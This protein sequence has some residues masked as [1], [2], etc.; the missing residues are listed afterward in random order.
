MSTMNR[1][2][3]KFSAYLRCRV[4]RGENNQ[5]YLERYH[6][7]HLPFGIHIYLHRFVASDPGRALHNHPWR[8]ALSLVLCGG[9]EETRLAD[10]RRGHALC[11]RQVGAGL[12]PILCLLFH[13]RPKD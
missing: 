7:L 10:A 11:K 6:L 2:L 3:F 13:A 8:T 12:G 4:I 9:Y 1:L 5:P